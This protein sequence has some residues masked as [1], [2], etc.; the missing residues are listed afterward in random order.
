[1]YTYEYGFFSEAVVGSPLAFVQLSQEKEIPHQAVFIEVNEDNYEQLCKH[2]SSEGRQNVQIVLGDHSKIL[3]RYFQGGTRKRYGIVYADPTGTLPPFSL[4]GRMSR[5][6][7][8]A[9]L[10][11]LIYCSAANIKR[12]RHIHNRS[13]SEFLDEI[14]KEYWII[15]EAHGKHQWT[16]LLGTNWDSMPEFK[17]LGFHLATSS[18][19]QE[20]MESL[21]KTKAEVLGEEEQDE[22]KTSPTLFEYAAN[23]GSSKDAAGTSNVSYSERYYHGLRSVLLEY[24]SATVTIMPQG[25][26]V[27]DPEDNSAEGKFY[28]N[29]IVLD[30]AA[31]VSLSDF[32][33]GDVQL[34]EMFCDGLDEIRQRYPNSDIIVSPEWHVAVSQGK[35]DDDV[36]FTKDEMLAITLDE[37]SN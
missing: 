18:R 23:Q 21:D 25:H 24:A 27:I 15:R 26:V 4:L 1:M 8:Y 6:P 29:S 31:G 13:L 36:F 28:D 2:V 34:C 9:T 16:F 7:T 5:V 3:P 17:K 12:M 19:G 22:R 20:I 10:D 32:D 33:T 14:D 11:I 37:W 30:M 35:Y